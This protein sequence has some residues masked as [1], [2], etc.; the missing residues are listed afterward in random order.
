MQVHLPFFSYLPQTGGEKDKFVLNT[1]IRSFVPLL[2]CPSESNK[3]VRCHALSPCQPNPTS[4]GTAAKSERHSPHVVLHDID[5][6]RE[7]DVD[8]DEPGLVE[9]WTSSPCSQKKVPNSTIGA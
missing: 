5:N 1:G 7:M 2:P 8:G 3:H 6:A 9:T 4:S